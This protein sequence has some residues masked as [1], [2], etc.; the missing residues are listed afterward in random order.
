MFVCLNLGASSGESKSGR[1]HSLRCNFQSALNE[2]ACLRFPLHNIG[3]QCFGIR[4]TF[5][6]IG[7]CGTVRIGMQTFSCP[8]TQ[9]GCVEN[10]PVHQKICQ[11]IERSYFL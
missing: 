2:D 1:V 10:A 6:W 9:S 5:S 3:I 8:W 7:N 11:E 4:Q